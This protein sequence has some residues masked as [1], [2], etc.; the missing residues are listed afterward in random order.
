MELTAN[1]VSLGSGAPA[2]GEAL[3]SQCLLLDEYWIPVVDFILGTEDTVQVYL[4]SPTFQWKSPKGRR[5]LVCRSSK[6]FICVS[7]KHEGRRAHTHLESFTPP[8]SER[9]RLLE[10]EL[11]SFIQSPPSSERSLLFCRSGRLLI[12]W[13]TG[14]GV[15][16][17]NHHLHQSDHVSFADPAGCSSYRAP[18]ATCKDEAPTHRSTQTTPSRDLTLGVM[19]RPRGRG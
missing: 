15:L 11:E 9:S 6:A 18:H 5:P 7:K 3:K 19:H 14:V 4:S 2:R 10:L 1:I 12:L 8:S 16:L 13:S 17:F